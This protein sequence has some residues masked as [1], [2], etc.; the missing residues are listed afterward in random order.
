MA[1]SSAAG[2]GTVAVT[3]TG[4]GSVTSS[5]SVINC[6]ASNTSSCSATFPIGDVV[7][8]TA[9]GDVT[10]SGVTCTDPTTCT[11][12][13][14]GDVDVAAA[15]ACAAHGTQTVAYTG[16]V[17]MVSA[18]CA[19]SVTIDAQGGQGGNSSMAGVGGMGGRVQATLAIT[20]GQMLAVFVGNVGTAGTTVGGAG[21]FNGGGNGGAYTTAQAGGGGGG[22]TDIRLGGVDLASRVIVAGGGGGGATC[23]DV[24]NTGGLGG[25]PIGGVGP[26]ACAQPTSPAEPGTQTAGGAGGVYPGYTAGT[27]GTSGVGGLA[28]TD[29]GGGGGGGGYFGGGGASWGGGAGGSSYTDPVKATAV[30][31]SQG[32]RAGAGQVII[33]W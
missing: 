10:W 19:T 7:A 1:V 15:F 28:A 14:K 17:Q 3:V 32:F 12:T 21:G 6:S 23:S 24:A 20:E 11:I 2:T 33:T 5:P 4:G 29:N 22:A 16:A 26:T 31:H 8:L 27:A 9:S 13:V 25:G 18:G 30:T